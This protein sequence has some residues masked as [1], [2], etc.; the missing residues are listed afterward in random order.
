MMKEGQARTRPLSNIVHSPT[1]PQPALQGTTPSQSTSGN[2]AI[3]EFVHQI[4]QH[5]KRVLVESKRLVDLV[6]NLDHEGTNGA[7]DQQEEDISAPARETALATFELLDYVTKHAHLQ[8]KGIAL[9]C[10]QDNAKEVRSAVLDLVQAARSV[11][12]NPFD[13]LCKQT[14]DNARNTVVS[15][16]KA[17]IQAAESI[18][19][20]SDE[21]DEAEGGEFDIVQDIRAANKALQAIFLC[22]RQP[23]AQDVFLQSAKG[24]LD[25]I[26]QLMVISKTLGLGLEDRLKEDTSGV[27]NASKLLLRD[28]EDQAYH[29]RFQEAMK[30][31]QA[32]LKAFLYSCAKSKDGKAVEKATEKSVVR[33][34][35]ENVTF[36]GGPLQPIPEIPKSPPATPPDAPRGLPNKNSPAS[37]A[38]DSGSK[39]SLSNSQ[40]LKILVTKDGTQEAKVKKIIQD[41]TTILQTSMPL[42]KNEWNH[43]SVDNKNNIIGKL[44]AVI[45]KEMQPSL[46]LKSN[47]D[48]LT[49]SGLP[50]DSG[51]TMRPR[52]LL[53]SAGVGGGAEESEDAEA[54]LE[55]QKIMKLKNTADW[56]MMTMSLKSLSRRLSRKGVEAQDFPSLAEV[57]TSEIPSKLK[58]LSTSVGEATIDILIYVNASSMAV[59]RDLIETGKEASANLEAAVNNMFDIL[60]TT[61]AMTARWRTEEEDAKASKKLLPRPPHSPD[62]ERQRAHKQLVNKLLL[63][64][65]SAASSASRKGAHIEKIVGALNST[66]SSNA[67]YVKLKLEESLESRIYSESTAVRA[68][69][70]QMMSAI[71]AILAEQFAENFSN[72]LQMNA[73]ARSLMNTI[74]RLLDAIE[75]LKYITAAATATE[76]DNKSTTK[77]LEDEEKDVNI[78]EDHTEL[79]LGE[80][81][82]VKAGTLNG[83]IAR[84]TSDIQYDIKFVSTFIATYQSF[85]TPWKVLEKLMQRYTA[86]GKIDEKR[87]PPIQLRVCVV[88]KYWI[89]NQCADF[90][91]TLIKALNTFFSE[92]LPKDGHNELAKQLSKQLATK[93][94]E[95]SVKKKAMTADPFSAL[96]VQ[97]KMSPA[98]LFMALNESE[99]ARQ[100]T[101]IDFA[102][103]KKIQPSE[104]FNQSWN[105]PK[106]H[107]RAPH[108]LAMISRANHLSFWVGSFILWAPNIKERT[109]M[110][111]KFIKIGKHLRELNNFNTLMGVVAG[112][113]MSAISRL[114]NT[115]GEINKNEKTTLDGLQLL[116]NPSSSFKN[117]RQVLRNANPPCLPY[118]GS[119]LTDLTFMEDGNPDN[120]TH[121]GVPMINYYKRELVYNTLREIHMYQQSAYNFPVVE[122]I[123]TFLTALP[124]SEEKDLYE[125]SL[126]REPRQPSN[127]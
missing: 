79:V 114:K 2:D 56:G 43:L 50:D 73:S 36:R 107:H 98:D 25:A 64:T 21:D 48:S 51:I 47:I 18:Q 54:M 90:D 86:K 111:T 62:E 10:L 45:T 118:L 99:L 100:F 74:G 39:S 117:Y 102:L 29:S 67:H 59:Q 46:S 78:W 75:T 109:L 17:V 106:F 35:S 69:A 104:L 77:L 72:V 101:L 84:L 63:N 44:E 115:F 34:R 49:F 12:S 31:L 14:L 37:T 94:E 19:D 4:A 91:S 7:S 97:E 71:N 83:I 58:E 95:L 55:L 80:Q 93:V 57:P 113:N 123:H 26:G 38:N 85:T 60:K 125:L 61:I 15:S 53:L 92:T 120:V 82:T 33:S 121:N 126:Q 88:L 27:M 3:D 119:Y 66:S 52:S 41:L 42:F 112:I 103:F 81:Q 127:G 105:K 87:V 22:S 20:G 116:L 30:Q 9:T 96:Q 76:G 68:L 65:I 28:F 1:T 32:S 122:P 110:V 89:E 8:A 16:I 70:A 5:S 23:I 11:F 13:F 6:L 108:I 40:E 124:F 24:L